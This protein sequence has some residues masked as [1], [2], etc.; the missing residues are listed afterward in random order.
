MEASAGVNVEVKITG[1]STLSPE[2]VVIVKGLA[3]VPCVTK[4][5][6]RSCALL[7]ILTVMGRTWWERHSRYKSDRVVFV[8][9]DWEFERRDWCCT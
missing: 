1:L 2:V 5:A 7:K 9:V 8:I 4:L 3:N 6:S